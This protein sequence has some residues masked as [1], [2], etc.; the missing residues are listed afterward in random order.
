[1]IHFYICDVLLL[2]SIVKGAIKV[3]KECFEIS[4]Q[5]V[6]FIDRK[7]KNINFN[8]CYCYFS[9]LMAFT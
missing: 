3:G 9:T 1:M 5:G 6:N 7:N 2:I 8:F 4:I